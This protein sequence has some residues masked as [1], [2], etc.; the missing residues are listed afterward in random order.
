[1]EQIRVL[2]VLSGLNRGG[3]ENMVI[4]SALFPECKYPEDELAYFKTNEPFFRALI[5]AMEKNN[6]SILF[7]NTTIKHCG[8]N[9]YFPILGKDLNAFIDYM[10]HPLFGA[11]WDVGHAHMDAID[12][13]TE[14]MDFLSELCGCIAGCGLVKTVVTH[15]GIDQTHIG[16]EIGG[17][18]TAVGIVEKQRI[19]HGGKTA[20]AEGPVGD[21]VVD[22]GGCHVV[23]VLGVVFSSNGGHG[24]DELPRLEHYVANGIPHSSV[25]SRGGTDTVHHHA[26]NGFHSIFSFSSLVFVLLLKIFIIT[27]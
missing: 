14:I 12:H 10:D 25:F 26:R 4:H 5:P 13:Y 9:C 20:A 24:A 18:G 11:A 17:A 3:I 23:N 6:V 21:L 22:F 2:Q 1:M 8:D 19:S 27:L 15:P 7:E 16:W